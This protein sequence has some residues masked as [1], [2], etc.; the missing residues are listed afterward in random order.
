MKESCAIA[1][2]VRETRLRGAI[3][4]G[5]GEREERAGPLPV[6]H[7]PRDVGNRREP[8]RPR[9]RRCDGALRVSPKVIV[10]WGMEGLIRRQTE[11][12]GQ[13]GE[14]PIIPATVSL[15]AGSR[16][17]PYEV[18]ASL[19]AGGM[20]EVYRARDERLKRDVAIKVLPASFSTDAD[21]LRRFEQ[22]AQAAG[23]LR[24]VTPG[25]REPKAGSNRA[26]SSSSSRSKRT[27]AMRWPTPGWRTPM[28]S[29]APTVSRRPQSPFPG[30]ER[31]PGRRS[32]LTRVSRRPTP[33]SASPS[34]ITTTTGPPRNP[35]T[36]RPSSSI[37]TTLP[38]TIGT[39]CS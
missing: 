20:G 22:E 10:A 13:R 12:R 16:L 1:Q 29:L 15:T 14:R 7:T 17:G 35:S 34:R 30:Q 38:L 33:P 37:R 25:R 27:R 28:R 32:R 5:G 18:L 26:S 24:A 4:L 31:R 21:R 2:A 8:T 36:R 6:Y 19:G 39:V 9:E 23:S 3:R 11:V